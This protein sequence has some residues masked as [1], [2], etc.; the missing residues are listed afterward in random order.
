MARRSPRCSTARSIVQSSS[1]R[2]SSRVGVQLAPVHE[3]ARTATGCRARRAR[4]SPPPRRS[5]R[6]PRAPAP[7]SFRPPVR[8]TGRRER[9]HQARRELVVG[10]ALVLHRRRAGVEGDRRDPGLARPGGGPARSRSSSPGRRPERSLT[11]TGSRRARLAG[12]PRRSRAP[13]PPR[14]RGRPAA[15]RRRRSCA[16]SAPGSP[17]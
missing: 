1:A 3:L 6:T 9:V 7:A 5:A 11:V 4:A 10:D 16:P 15:P 8:I 12:R 13:P 14:A 2:T 17:C